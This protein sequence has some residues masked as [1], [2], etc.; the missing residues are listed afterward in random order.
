MIEN[1]N[2]MVWNFAPILNI[3]ETNFNGALE[4]FYKIGVSGLV[5]ENIQNSLDGRLKELYKPV[6]VDIKIGNIEKENIP[7]IEEIIARINC[8]KGHNSYTRE[9]IEHMKKS[10]EREEIHYISFEDSNTKGLTGAKNGQSNSDK[11]TWGIYAYKKGVHSIEDD[12]NFESERGGSHGIGKIASNAASDLFMMYFANCDEDNNKHLGGTIQLVEHEYENISYRSTGYFTDI[13]NNKYFPFE[14]KF[15]NEFSKDTRG[16]KII[17]P[18]LRDEFNDEKK[19]IKSVCE[20]FFVAILNEKLIVNVNDKVLDKD[21]ISYYIESEEY[22]NQIISEI[23]K[24]FTPL[25]LETYKK[26]KLKEIEIKSLNDVYKFD[27]YFRIEENIRKGRLGVIR[28]VGMK[29]QD[30]VIKSNATKPFNA[31]LIPKSIKEDKFLKSLENESHTEISSDH[32]K[33]PNIKKDAKKFINNISNVLSNIISEEMKKLIETDGIIDTKDI[34]Y[35]MESKFKKD[36]KGLEEKVIIKDSE[37]KTEKFNKDTGKKRKKHT[38]DTDN[39]GK[40]KD[41]TKKTRK[42]STKNS[43]TE[44]SDECL[45]REIS[46]KNSE[47]KENRQSRYIVKPT[48]VERLLL[49]EKE[50]VKI[51]LSGCKK[52]RNAKECDLGISIVDGMGNEFENEFNIKDNYLKVIDMSTGKL[53][54]ISDNKIKNVTINNGIINVEMELSSNI[55]KTLKFI[56]YVEV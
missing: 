19:I 29:I 53:C 21:T 41:G 14:N 10:I 4:R 51:N 7:G 54:D 49:K 6:I 39:G 37:G 33:D 30:K 18:F 24:E 11:D 46:V 48:V 15:S 22:Y 27:L 36:L 13:E 43:K 23:T 55:N 2:K 52:E 3:E 26:Y 17:I 12:S 50:Y 32:L 28:S 56:Y 25:Y 8:L 42:K 38:Q 31:V 44:S 16:L 9:T 47:G 1:K 5:R 40:N 35:T 34:I 45:L 20:S